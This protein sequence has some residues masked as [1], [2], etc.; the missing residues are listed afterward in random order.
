MMVEERKDFESGGEDISATKDESEI[1]TGTPLHDS[2]EAETPLYVAGEKMK[3]V[4]SIG[5]GTPLNEPDTTEEPVAAT[6][7]EDHF[8]A[9]PVTDEPVQAETAA[10]F[11]EVPVDETPNLEEDFAQE[12]DKT[13]ENE[14]SPGEVI[15]G[16]VIRIDDDG[17][18]VD[19]GYK[20]E[21]II[22][23]AEFLNAKGEF[24]TQVGDEVEVLLERRENREGLLVLSKQKVDKRK[25]WNMAKAALA[26]NSSMEGM[27]FQKCKGGFMV[28][29]GGSQAFLPS[30]Q[31]DVAQVKNP[32]AFLDKT[33]K[34]KII[35]MNR[36]RGNIVVSRR[37]H[38]LEDRDKKRTDAISKLTP[39]RMVHGVVKNITNFGAFIDI[40][41]I[42]ALLHVN[43][44]SWAKVS[45]PRHIVNIGDEIEVLVLSIDQEA[46]KVALGLKQKSEDP[47]LNI[48]EKYPK[49][50][51]VEGEVV[52]LTDFGAF[53][54]LENGVE[55]LLP[56]SELSWTRRVRHPKEILKMGDTVRVKVLSMDA[57]AK[58]IT[59]G[60]RQTEQE[61]FSLYAESHKAGAV[62]VGEVKTLARYGAFVELAE[63]V[64]GLLH[65]SDLSWNGSVKEPGDVLKVGER[66]EVK[67]LEI[68]TDQKKVA[69]GLKQLGE[70]PWVEASKK[71]TMGSIVKAKVVRNTKFGAFVELEPGVE[72]LVH[73]SQLVKEK[74]KNDPEPLTEG[75]VVDVKVVKMNREEHKIGLSVREALVAQEAAEMRKYLSP[76][77]KPGFSLGEAS[78]VDL[79]ELKKR[80]ESKSEN[81]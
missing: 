73:I 4:V 23:R 35:K 46:G 56:V 20:S 42:D 19:I 30:S 34:F 25:S 37:N 65:I 24:T 51:M 49:D 63:G 72:G 14:P 60:L 5:P 7:S 41:G 61:P 1:G 80:L 9:T 62:V 43:D 31:L 55:G 15:R 16:R 53:L 52:S 38:L 69:L 70:D 66:V 45:H 36:E 32:D 75:E 27:I 22:D 54:R 79:E 26:N 67:L 8:E 29:L 77:N 48:T 81:Q 44:M 50:S 3:P 2:E 64:T 28:D 10:P 33:H 74:G 21:G 76:E 47:W 17:V 78:G 59:L 39:G 40:G 12:L 18:V 11:A 6:P 57:G 68:N 58:K 13:L 71:Y